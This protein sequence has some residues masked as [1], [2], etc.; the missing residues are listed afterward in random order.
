[1]T[2]QALIHFVILH[3]GQISKAAEFLEQLPG[4]ELSLVAI[5]ILKPSGAQIGAPFHQPPSGEPLDDA[6]PRCA[7][8]NSWTIE[9]FPNGARPVVRQ[10]RVGVE[11]DEDVTR[12]SRC[13]SIHLPGATEPGANHRSSGGGDG[14]RVV[15]AAAIGDNDFVR[16]ASAHRLKRCGEMCRSVQRGDDDGNPA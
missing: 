11:K 16:A 8:D 15:G 13:A 6:K 5:G 1:M 4:Q 10:Q 7:G 14:A 12:G 2:S 9:G 3:D